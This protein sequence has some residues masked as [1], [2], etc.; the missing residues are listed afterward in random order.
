MPIFKQLRANDWEVRLA[1]YSVCRQIICAHHYTH[2][3]GNTAT[4]TFG[5][6]CR[7]DLG[8][9]RGAAMWLP[10]MRP[11]CAMYNARYG[12]DADAGLSLSRLAI[13]PDVP[14]NAASFMLGQM[15]AYLR[16]E[17]RWQWCV[18]WADMREG[19]TGAIYKAANWTYDGV[20]P[21]APVW[22]DGSG[23]PVST[24]K[25]PAR[26]RAN[27]TTREMIEAG[28]MRLPSVGKHRYHKLIK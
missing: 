27:R 24:R 17:G 19:H 22:V 16:K 25:G 11:V 10:P 9:C 15:H 7:N 23:H 18:T 6:Y 26:A 14:S 13:A 21:A 8:T 2:T 4:H 1:P 28:C 5:L 12:W 20:A 3:C